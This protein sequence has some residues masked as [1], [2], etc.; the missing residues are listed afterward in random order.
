LLQG[1]EIDLETVSYRQLVDLVHDGE[2]EP[3]GRQQDGYVLGFGGDVGCRI[4][5]L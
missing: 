3:A 2:R 5:L 4:H 1:G